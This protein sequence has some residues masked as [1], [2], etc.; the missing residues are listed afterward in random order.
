VNCGP[1]AL[2]DVNGLKIVVVSVRQ[3]ANDRGHFKLV[4]IQ[5]E[6]EPLLV[7][8]SRGHFR[9][10]F[11]PIARTIIEVDAPGAA[12]PNLE[13]F[14]FQHVRRPIWPL[15]PDTGWDGNTEQ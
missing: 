4:G 5:P 6:H 1:T 13:R 12:N 15:D 14:T 10:D 9:A 7:I 8:K 2:V 3:A 11:E